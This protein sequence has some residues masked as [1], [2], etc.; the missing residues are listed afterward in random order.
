M[1]KQTN[2]QADATSVSDGSIARNAA[3]SEHAGAQGRYVIE[4]IGPVEHRR[5]EYVQLRDKII[6]REGETTLKRVLGALKFRPSLR[7]LESAFASIPVEPKWSAVIDNVVT[8]EGAR[9]GLTNHLKGSAFTQTVFMGL[10][11]STGYGFAGAQGSGVAVTN[12]ASSITAA[13]GAS[14]ANGWNEAQVGVCAARGTPSFGTASSRSLALS[15]AVAFSILGTVTVKGVFLMVKSSAG[16]AATSTVG[17]TA[18]AIYSAG[19]FSGGDKPAANGDT[20]NV[21]YT[22]SL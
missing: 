19:L 6:A 5:A 17:N 7:K 3:V 4:A 15:A 10:I 9:A 2:E 13:G 8:D 16:V 11:E 18:G 1:N 22:A 12:L 21:S 14:P 20:L